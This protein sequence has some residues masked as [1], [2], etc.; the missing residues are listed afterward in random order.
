[1]NYRMTARWVG[2][3][4]EVV[5]SAYLHLIPDEKT[6]IADFRNGEPKAEVIRSNLKY[7]QIKPDLVLR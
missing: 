6:P 4:E 2:G 3:T 7:I 1:M 5:L